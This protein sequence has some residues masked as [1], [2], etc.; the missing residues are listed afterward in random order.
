[1]ANE[2]TRPSD[3]AFEQSDAFQTFE[4]NAVISDRLNSYKKQFYCIDIM[5]GKI[6]LSKYAQLFTEQDTKILELKHKC[7]LYDRRVSLALI[8]FYMQKIDFLESQL[9]GALAKKDKEFLK[10]VLRNVQQEKTLETQ[11]INKDANE[12]Y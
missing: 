4:N 10:S 7:K 2:L 6:V 8:P 9:R 12:I 1:M 11:Q 3:L 5:V